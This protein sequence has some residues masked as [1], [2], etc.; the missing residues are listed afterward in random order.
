M[1]VIKTLIKYNNTNKKKMAYHFEDDKTDVF[2]E[3][4]LGTWEVC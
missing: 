4:Y 1:D 3:E 2:F